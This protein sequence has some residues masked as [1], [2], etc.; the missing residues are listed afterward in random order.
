MSGRPQKLWLFV[1]VLCHS[2][3][4][5]AEFGTATDGTAVIRGLVHA[6]QY[7][8]GRPQEVLFDNMKPS[9]QRPK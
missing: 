7:F 4:T 6:V 5:Y 3:M 8:G 2:R 1:M 9:V